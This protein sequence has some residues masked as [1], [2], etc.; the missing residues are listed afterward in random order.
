[1]ASVTEK[2]GFIPEYTV[3]AYNQ[4]AYVMTQKKKEKDK[5]KN[6]DKK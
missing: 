4:Y 3:Q 6:S 2:N 1:M 5:K